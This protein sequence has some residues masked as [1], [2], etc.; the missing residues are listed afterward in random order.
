MWKETQSLVLEAL[1]IK[2]KFCQKIQEFWE[3]VL[4]IIK[5]IIGQEIPSNPKCLFLGVHPGNLITNNKECA[6]IDR[7]ILQARR[8]IAESWKSMDKPS[9]SQY[10]RELSACVVM[11]KEEE[12]GYV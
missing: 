7:C 1:C 9:I 8:I 10:T 2:L 12:I 4:R 11:E 6:L 3:W 5:D